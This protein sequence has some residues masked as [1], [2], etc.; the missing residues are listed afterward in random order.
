MDSLLETTETFIRTHQTW[1][2]VIVGFIAFGESIVIL[3]LIIPATALMLLI[4]G[5]V[6]SGVIDPFPVVTGA[7]LG[8]VLGDIVSYMMGKWLGPSVVHRWPLRH[9]RER[10]AQVRLFFR[11]Y[12]FFAVFFG[13]FCGP[14][15]CTVPLVAGMIGM[16]QHRFQAANITS[17]ILWVPVLL[18]PGWLAA[19]GAEQFGE[20]TEVHWLGL[21]VLATAIA[22]LIAFVGALITRR[23][24]PAR[25]RPSR[26]R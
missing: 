5:L 1:A 11:K 18:A 12:G 24:P 21:A 6:G 14:L 19:K 7:I 2:G 20:L 22:I 8:A 10:I 26:A 23:M 13:R 17:A 4:G 15:R 3:G 25:K 16:D 9:Y